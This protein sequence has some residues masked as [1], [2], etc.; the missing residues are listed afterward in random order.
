M[1]NKTE[2]KEND[3]KEMKEKYVTYKFEDEHNHRRYELGFLLNGFLMLIRIYDSTN[4]LILEEYV[5]DHCGSFYYYQDLEM[6]G[7]FKITRED[8][9]GPVD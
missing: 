3:R 2:S 1:T 5:G 7:N 4:N 9:A 8:P 6:V